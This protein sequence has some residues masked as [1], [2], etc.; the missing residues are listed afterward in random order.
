MAY[1]ITNNIK[2]RTLF[3]VTETNLEYNDEI[4]FPG[5]SDGTGQGV[6]KKIFLSEEEAEKYRREMNEDIVNKHIKE[7]IEEEGGTDRSTWDAHNLQEE[8][9]IR[10]WNLF[11]IHTLTL[12]R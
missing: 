11:R 7:L 2:G 5:D 8:D 4:Y 6:P 12:E 3:I 9:N 10:S 1:N